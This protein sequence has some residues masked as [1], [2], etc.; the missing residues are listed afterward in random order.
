[1]HTVLSRD[2]MHPEEFRGIAASQLAKYPSIQVQK[3]NIV[4]VAQ[5]EVA[6]GYSGFKAVDG[7]Q[8]LWGTPL[9]AAVRCLPTKC[10][11]GYFGSQG[12]VRHCRAA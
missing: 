8:S 5:A 10:H 2:G 11:G 4:S 9:H 1:M 3:A 6:P 12:C 7:K